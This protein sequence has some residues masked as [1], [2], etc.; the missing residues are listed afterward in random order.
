VPEGEFFGVIAPV[1]G[2]RA[3]RPTATAS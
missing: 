3:G 2:A 1:P